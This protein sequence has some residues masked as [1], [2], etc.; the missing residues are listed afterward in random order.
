M[1]SL[2]VYLYKQTSKM[3]DVLS[4]LQN[5]FTLPLQLLALYE[6]VLLLCT[7][8]TSHIWSTSTHTA[9]CIEVL[10]RDFSLSISLLSLTLCGLSSLP[11]NC[12]ILLLVL[13]LLQHA[14]DIYSKPSNRIHSLLRRLVLPVYLH[15]LILTLSNSLTPYV[16]SML[17]LICTLLV[18][19]FLLFFPIS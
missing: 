2:I 17:I 6:I 5:F 15:S 16:N 1:L 10:S 9:F 8:F 12:C 11:S 19:F 3:L 4:F 14:K 7:E 13:S 18:I